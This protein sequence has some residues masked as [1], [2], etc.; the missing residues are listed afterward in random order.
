MLGW[1]RRLGLLVPANNG[2]I[3]PELA[4]WLPEGAALHATRMIVEGPFEPAALQRMERQA[5]RG[6]A[7]L[8][9]TRVDAIAYA[10]L[11][12]SLVKG[13]A[14]DA[15]FARRS[16]LPAFTAA[17]ATVEA[18][19]A[20]GARRIAL[21]SPYPASIQALVEPYFRARGFQ[22]TAAS[23][24]DAGDYEAVTRIPPWEL[25]RVARGLDL[26]AA[27]ALCVL[28]TDLQTL[29]VIETLEAD[30]GVPVVTSNQA[31]LWKGLRGIAT[32]G[33]GRLMTG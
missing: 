21:V 26:G 10:C 25:Y 12:T 11:A 24:L 2:V 19:S 15:A 14:W 20:V 6:L 1:R 29:A 13:A 33:P 7:E 30:L 22:V 32:R 4:A 23:S 17:T 28:A 3:E 16:P 8:E 18:L 9:L 27:D 31:I 5:E